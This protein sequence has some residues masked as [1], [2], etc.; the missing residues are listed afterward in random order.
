[1]I[2][3]VVENEAGYYFPECFTDAD[4]PQAQFY[5]ML[6]R[7]LTHKLNNLQAVVQGFAS[8]LDMT[9]GLDEAARENI[10]HMKEASQNASKLVEK[11][12]FAG[13]CSKVEPSRVSLADTIPMLLE[14]LREEVSPYNVLFNVNLSPDLP[15]VMAD[16]TRFR[17]VLFALVINAAEAAQG[18]GEISL[19]VLSPGQVPDTPQ[20]HVD[21][22]IRNTGSEIPADKIEQ[23]FDPF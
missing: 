8:L 1:M 14:S 22:F 23:V 19:D 7:G 4:T 16:Q 12:L 17:E 10:Q 18:K 13:G 6:L 21:I 2:K 3:P 20:T 5:H 11:T 15:L 9:D